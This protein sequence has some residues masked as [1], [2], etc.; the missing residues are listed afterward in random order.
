MW[1]STKIP[2][3]PEAGV[4]RGIAA[5][6]DYWGRFTENF[7]QFTFE[8]EDFVDIGGERVLVLSRLTTRG[9]GSGATVEVRPGWIYTIRA[10]LDGADRRILRPG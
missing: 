8:V 9:R 10:G 3:F 2:R 1:N 4:Y 6:R 5:V 7:D